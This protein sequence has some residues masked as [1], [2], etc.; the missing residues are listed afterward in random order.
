M[1]LSP[2]SPSLVVPPLSRLATPLL[3]RRPSLIAPPP[4]SLRH[5]SLELAGCY[6]AASLVVPLTPPRAHPQGMIWLGEVA[7]MKR[8]GGPLRQ[9][10]MDRVKMWSGPV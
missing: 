1:P 3:S 9:K 4:L 6:I 7:V 8:R 5:A 2:L 10:N